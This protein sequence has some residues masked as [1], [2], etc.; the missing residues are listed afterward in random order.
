VDVATLLDR[1]DQ[2]WRSLGRE[3]WL[4]AFAGHPR[5]GERSGSAWSQREQAGTEG[6]RAE[7]MQAL[8]DGNQA[9]EQRFGHIYIVCASGRSADEML[10]DLMRRMHNDPD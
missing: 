5:I 7:V 3:D 9:Y 4:A 10:A 2:V 6:A 8:L 1:S